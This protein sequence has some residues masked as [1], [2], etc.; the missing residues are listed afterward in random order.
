M[1]RGTHLFRDSWVFFGKEDQHCQCEEYGSSLNLTSSV[2]ICQVTT[3]MNY[4][5]QTLGFHQL[6]DKKMV[7]STVG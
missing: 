4:Q 3:L 2:Y 1:S 7:L 6:V 5:L